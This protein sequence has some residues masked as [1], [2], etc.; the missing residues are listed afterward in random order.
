MP[1]MSSALTDID[2]HYDVIV[3]GSGY[4]GGIAASRLARAKRRVCVLERGREWLPGEFPDTEREALDQIQIGT[5]DGRVGIDTGLYD[6]HLDEDISVFRGCGLGGTS[7]INA[8]VSLEAD[9]RVFEDARWPAELRGDLATRL[10]EGYQHA[11]TLLRPQPFPATRNLAKL[12]ALER[13]ATLTGG[14]FYRPPIN[15]TFE[16]GVNNVGVEQHACTLCGDCVTGCNDGAKN[17]IAMTYLPDAWNHGAEIFTEAEVRW[18]ERVGSEWLVHYEPRGAGRELFEGGSDLVVRA[19]IVILAAGTLGSTEILLRSREKGLSLSARLGHGFTGNG[20]VLAFGYNTDSPVNAIGAGERDPTSMDP[21]GPCITG[22][23]DIRGTDGVRAGLVIEDGVAPGAVGRLLPKAWAIEAGLRGRDTDPGLLDFFEERQRE[24]ASLARGP[25]HGAARNTQTFLVM[26]HDDA[27][28]RILLDE[29]GRLRIS[30]PGVSAQPVFAEV[31]RTLEKAT[32]AN[33]GTLVSNPMWSNHVKSNLVTVHPLGGCT[34]GANGLQ[35]VTNHA[36]SVFAGPG[37]DVHDGLHVMDGSVIPTSLG[38]N[39]LLTISAVAERNVKLLA[40][41]R[42]WTIDYT[43]PSHPATAPLTVRSGVRFTERM[44]GWFSTVETADF[45]EAVALGEAEGS[46]LRFTLTLATPDLDAMLADPRHRM[47]MIGTVECAA[48]WGAPLT[49][50]QGTFELLPDNPNY[51][52]TKNMVYRMH[53]RGRDGAIFQFYGVKHVRDDAGLDSWSDTTTL[54]A[55]LRS[56]ESADGAISGRGIMYISPANLARQ[57]ATVRVTGATTPIDRLD[58]ISR[59]GRFFMGELFEV[60]GK[61][62]TRPTDF[63]PDAPPRA[64]RELRAPKPE[65]VPFRASDGAML[66]LTRYRGGSKGPVLLCHGLGVSSRM[67]TLDTIDTNLVEY[68]TGHGFDTWLLD[69]RASVALAAS[70]LQSTA[71]DVASID[72]PQAVAK[73]LSLTSARDLQ[74]VVHCYGSTTFFMAMLAG[75]RGVRSAVASQ[76]A[77]HVVPGMATKLKSGLYLPSTLA[78]LGVKSLTAYTD[79]HA[80]WCD[81]LFNAAVRLGPREAQEHCKSSTCHRISFLYALLYEHD[82][83]NALTHKTLHELFGVGNMAA[84][85]H[86]ARL[87]RAGTLVDARGRD[88]YMPHAKRLAIPITFIHGAENECYL[89]ESTERTRDWLGSANDSSLYRRHVIA[90]FG[91]IDCIL[92]ARAA[93]HV[94][95]LILDHLH[96]T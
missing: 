4:G 66:Q 94:Y 44:E 21:A 45:K 61:G 96:D 58:T 30:W 65:V 89:P 23:I 11:R 52:G 13:S 74:A 86:L 17:T 12:A 54:Y 25:Y 27:Q 29:Q 67:F 3:I 9:I 68:L 78:A 88:V 39:P 37:T 71:D 70:R 53:L 20:D 48:L 85:E 83:L 93:E 51:V 90:D 62:L 33:G 32:T 41:R 91:H 81:R 77:C 26:A 22:I 38:V 8:N 49:V 10:A 87:V 43:M 63:D 79:T 56:G 19:P 69:Y 40:E 18:I 82:Q 6:F 28:G 76:I 36:G 64:Q 42:G 35:G 2:A 60:Y 7:L 5:R 46:R 16:H 1:R 31:A 92:G 75:L 47:S 55:T 57:L 80:D 50:E 34:M 59:F 15:V 72:Y 95:P 84:F 73:V 14:A 24:L